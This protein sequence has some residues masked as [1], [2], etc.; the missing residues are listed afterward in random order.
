MLRSAA[1]L[2]LLA[3]GCGDSRPMGIVHGSISVDGMPLPDGN[4]VFFSV[5]DRQPPAA[6]TVVDGRFHAKV[7]VGKVRLEIHSL[8]VLRPAKL[9]D[10]EGLVRDRIPPRYNA[11]ESITLDVQP[12]DNPVTWNLTAKPEGKR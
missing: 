1:V 6:A 11:G 8:E 12:G 7:P 10:D 3:L 2:A 9:P 5:D 4:V